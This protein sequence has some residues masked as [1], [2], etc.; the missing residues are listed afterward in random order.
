M[1][2]TE[3][4]NEEWTVNRS[5][6]STVTSR[7]RVPSS[8]PCCQSTS[9]LIRAFSSLAIAA[10]KIAG[11][12]L[13]L[14]LLGRVLSAIQN[15]ARK[16]AIGVDNES[17]QTWMYGTVYYLSGTAD[18][19]LPYKV[20][21]GKQWFSPVSFVVRPFVKG[22]N[23]NTI[24]LGRVVRIVA[25]QLSQRLKT[26]LFSFPQVKLCCFLREKPQDPSPG[27]L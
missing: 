1:M 16:A 8:A 26:I 2:L 17:G 21:H 3:R 25:H 18:K 20:E 14:D 24:L 23:F 9:P 6:Y 27:E 7:F 4:R 13:A 15:V 19:V 22:L 10:A 12:Q 11:G 5:F